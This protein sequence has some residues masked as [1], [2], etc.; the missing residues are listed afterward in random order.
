MQTNCF[1]NAAVAG[2]AVAKIQKSGQ[3]AEASGFKKE[4][5]MT[6]AGVGAVVSAVHAY[7]GFRTWKDDVDGVE[8]EARGF[9]GRVQNKA[10]K[11]KNKA[12]NAIS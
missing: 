2:L 7:Y 12:Q 8:R 5:L 9:F 4:K 6:V 11:A 3:V 10:E 1:H